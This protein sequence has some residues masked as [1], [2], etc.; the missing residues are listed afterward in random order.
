MIIG[1]FLSIMEN[2]LSN[3]ASN[4]HNVDFIP[5]SAYLLVNINTGL[6]IMRVSYFLTSF[7]LT[8]S[9]F[10]S[11]FTLAKQPRDDH[12][13][14][15]RPTAEEMI[16]DGLIYRPLGLA[17]TIV[18]TGLFI[19]TLPFSLLGGNADDAADRLVVEPAKNTFTRCLGCG[20]YKHGIHR[21]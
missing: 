15:Y 9:L 1:E 14:H 8:I 3:M 19:V 16:V 5:T 18:G 4:T 13:T 17:G 7:I 12:A 2:C 21:R 20:I 11:S 6:T 10:Y